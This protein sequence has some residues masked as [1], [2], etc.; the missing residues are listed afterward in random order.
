V[1]HF[2]LFWYVPNVIDF[3]R[4][5]LVFKGMQYAFVK[6]KWAHFIFYYYVAI[7]MDVIDGAFARIL[8]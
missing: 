7:A 6:E 4:Y 1:T 8:D 2:R 3:L 5:I